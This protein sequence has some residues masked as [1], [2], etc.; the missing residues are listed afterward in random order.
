FREH[1]SVAQRRLEFQLPRTPAARVIERRECT[2]GPETSLIQQ[3][4]LD[5]Q[6]GTGASQWHTKVGTV[7]LRI[8]P[9]QRGPGIGEQAGSLLRASWLT[10]PTRFGGHG[11]FKHPPDVTGMPTG[12]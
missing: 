9:D 2:T 1:E 6:S 10:A 3:V 8:G 11:C 12:D 4:Q 7:V 5:K